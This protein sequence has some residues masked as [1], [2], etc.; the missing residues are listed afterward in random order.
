MSTR[1]ETIEVPNTP[2]AYINN[3]ESRT[4]RRF[5]GML[6]GGGSTLFLAACAKSQTEARGFP[7][8][9]VTAGAHT[10]EAAP[11]VTE[12][13]FKPLFESDEAIQNAIARLGLKRE[14]YP[15]RFHD[16]DRN[17]IHKPYLIPPPVFNAPNCSKMPN[18][19]EG[20][21]NTL[22]TEVSFSK[23]IPQDPNQAILEAVEAAKSGDPNL[24][25]RNIRQT[26]LS[27]GEK[28]LI[29]YYAFDSSITNNIEGM[30]VND[31]STAQELAANE[32]LH[33]RDMFCDSWI[34]RR[35]Y[36]GVR[37]RKVWDY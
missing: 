23:P 13:P 25:A 11:V 1:L 33:M 29:V 34:Q 19:F 2:S 16:I 6:A 7:R 26:S 24:A 35:L 17:G 37:M 15:S 3:P 27:I 20:I 18:D 32:Q 14:S 21:I 5:L 4:R 28:V 8:A 31:K 22:A 30:T 12:I 10:K 36:D 9:T